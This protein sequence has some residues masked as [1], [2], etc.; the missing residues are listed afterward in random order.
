MS[1][2]SGSTPGDSKAS[3]STS[4]KIC[5]HERYQDR[6]AICLTY[7]PPGGGQCAHLIASSEEG[8][9]T[10]DHGLYLGLIDS[11]YSRSSEDNGFLL[12]GGCHAG[13]F[14]LKHVALSPAREILEYIVESL[15]D[16]TNTKRVHEICESL[17]KLTKDAQNAHEKEKCLIPYLGLYS[18]I[19]LQPDLVQKGFFITPMLPA[20]SIVQGTQFVPA[21]LGTDPNSPH[22]ARIFDSIAAQSVATLPLSPSVIPLTDHFADFPQR[23]LWRIPLRLD[24]VLTEFVD[25]IDPW[26]DYV[27]RSEQN[28]AALIKLHISWHKQILKMQE[29]VPTRAVGSGPPIG[30]ADREGGGSSCSDVG[31]TA[32]AGVHSDDPQTG[33]RKRA[34]MRQDSESVDI[35]KWAAA[36]TPH[37][38][39]PEKYLDDNVEVLSQSQCV[40]GSLFSSR[41][42][43]PLPNN[44]IGKAFSDHTESSP[45]PPEHPRWRFRPDMSSNEIVFAAR[46]FVLF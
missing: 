41:L 31:P 29:A 20:L 13:L 10:I 39:G 24:A 19:T 35:A 3:F 2:L 27:P 22:V 40:C 43:F 6:C 36:T 11:S 16:P 21:P 4:V 25:R 7:V 9:L 33:P 34:R 44:L 37:N 38:D 5:I 32:S 26:G 23:R 15:L 18:L 17:T 14:T 45:V 42:T 1:L 12:C 8:A 46:A 30:F 28:C